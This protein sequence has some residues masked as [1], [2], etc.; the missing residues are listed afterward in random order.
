MQSKSLHFLNWRGGD[1]KKGEKFSPKRRGRFK[2]IDKPLRAFDGKRQ[3]IHPEQE[4]E[5]TPTGKQK[6]LKEKERAKH[7]FEL[8]LGSLHLPS[9]NQF[10]QQGDERMTINRKK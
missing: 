3:N 2:K 10:H 7:T 4:G 9:S 1:S 8:P 5:M 6:Y